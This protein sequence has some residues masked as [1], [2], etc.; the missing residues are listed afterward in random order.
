MAA[1]VE[2]KIY[3]A[4]L[5]RCQ[6]FIPPSGVT[7]V[8]PGVVFAPS[9]T[10]KFVNVEVHFNRSIETDISLEMDPIRQ[11]FI[12]TNVMWPKTSALLDAVDLAG[13]LRTLFRRGTKLL[14]DDT[15]VRFDEDPE[16]G[17]VVTGQTH[18]TIPVTSRWN[19]Q[20]QV[21]A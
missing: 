4:L 17:S 6:E 2:T 14:K 16:L 8:L 1:T 10:T 3:Q 12:R 19:C 20:P 11:G 9:S 15:Q 21:P 13:Q 7:I 5:A 18:E